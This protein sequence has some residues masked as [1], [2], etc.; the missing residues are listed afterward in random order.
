MNVPYMTHETPTAGHPL[1]VSNGFFPAAVHSATIFVEQI[2]GQAFDFNVS[3]QPGESKLA[4]AP[5]NC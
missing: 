4:Q 3:V 5:V 1:G 2:S